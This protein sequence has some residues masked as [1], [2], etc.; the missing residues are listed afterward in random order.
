MDGLLAQSVVTRADGPLK[1]TYLPVHRCPNI[2]TSISS[3]TGTF[4]LRVTPSVREAPDL[5]NNVSLGNI[6]ASLI[7]P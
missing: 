3:V 1:H 2:S 7:G 6:V 4:G 5:F